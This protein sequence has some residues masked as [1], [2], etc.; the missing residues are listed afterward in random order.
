VQRLDLV[1]RR[2]SQRPSDLIG[3]TEPYTALALDEAVAIIAILAE[4]EQEKPSPTWDTTSGLLPTG[5]FPV[6]SEQ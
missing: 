5:R 2:Y 6:L 4:A 3:I 1:A